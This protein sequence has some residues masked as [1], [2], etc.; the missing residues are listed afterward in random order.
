MTTIEKTR[1]ELL[2]ACDEESAKVL[3][4]DRGTGTPDSGKLIREGIRAARRAIEE[5]PAE[6]SVEEYLAR[7]LARLDA[8]AARL[9]A[10]PVSEDGWRDEDGWIVGGLNTLR[11]AVERRRSKPAGL[12]SR[13]RAR[14]KRRR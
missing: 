10:D 4:Q 5:T 6:W 9:R 7:V 1:D 11:G 8:E 2:R 12:W 14:L 3:R 13:L